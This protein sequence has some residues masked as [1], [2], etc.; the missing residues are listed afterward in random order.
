[1]TQIYQISLHAGAYDGRDKTREQIQAETG[2]KPLEGWRDPLLNRPMLSGEVGCAISHLRVW[3]KIADS[4]QNGI[5]L[6]EDAVYENLDVAHV[7]E[8]LKTHDSVWLGYR[9][10]SIGYWYNAHAYAITLET[11]RYLLSQGFQDSLVH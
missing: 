1:M 2:C 9:E 7:D 10:N 6:E 5:I 8:L 11:A 3:E 4:G